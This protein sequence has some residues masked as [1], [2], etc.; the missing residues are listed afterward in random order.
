MVRA[1]R[2]VVLFVHISLQ[3]QP[4]CRVG[5]AL[6]A[7]VACT[8]ALDV[9][10]VCCRGHIVHKLLSRLLFLLGD[11]VILPSASAV[12]VV[13]TGLADRDFIAGLCHL[14]TNVEFEQLINKLRRVFCILI[15]C[16]QLIMHRIVRFAGSDLLNGQLCVII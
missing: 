5:A 1:V 3:Y 9:P 12:L 14:N 15:L 16:Q 13:Q 10:D 8:H 7:W 2:E 11:V 6:N 4:D